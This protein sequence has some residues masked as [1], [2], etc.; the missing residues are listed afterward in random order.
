MKYRIRYQH[1]HG[2]LADGS[3]VIRTGKLPMSGK[4]IEFIGTTDCF[5]ES[6]RQGD[7][8]GWD[9]VSEGR[10]YCLK[11]DNFSKKEG[12]LHSF[13]KAIKNVPS[14]IRN[15]I[16]GLYYSKAKSVEVPDAIQD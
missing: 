8:K 4:K 15:H 10:A 2:V 16:I 9:P 1:I 3:P 13:Y 11:G 14:H 7:I 5:V 6:E 12:R